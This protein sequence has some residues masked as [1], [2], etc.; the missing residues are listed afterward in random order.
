MIIALGPK[1]LAVYVRRCLPAEEVVHVPIAGQGRQPAQRSARPKPG[2]LERVS[3]RVPNEFVSRIQTLLRTVDPVSHTEP[4][5]LTR[6]LALLDDN[7]HAVVMCVGRRGRR[8]GWK[9][10]QRRPSRIVLSG[11]EPATCILQLI[12]AK[13]LPRTAMGAREAVLGPAFVLARE[14]AGEPSRR[15]RLALVSP[16]DFDDD[17]QLLAV[18]GELADAGHD[19]TVVTPHPRGGK[20]A[21]MHG[22]AL[23]LRLPVH[24]VATRWAEDAPNRVG[25][26]LLGY[27]SRTQADAAV[28]QAR[29]ESVRHSVGAP[30]PLST[31]AQRLRR[32]AVVLRAATHDWNRARLEK[33]LSTVGADPH[34]RGLQG[35]G[36]STLAH[37]TDLEASLSDALLTLQPDVLYAVGRAALAISVV[38][39]ARLRAQ[40]LDVRLVY[41]ET[42]DDGGGGLDEGLE[43]YL[44]STERRFRARARPGRGSPLQ[45]SAARAAQVR[46]VDGGEMTRL[47]KPS[48]RSAASD[49]AVLIGIQNSAGQAFQW[50]AALRRAGWPATSIQLMRESSSF[51]FQSDVVVTP[52]Q[53]SSFETRARAL[54]ELAPRHRHVLVESGRP[55]FELSSGLTQEVEL[56]R[57]SG[58]SVSM[59]FH[60]SDIRRPGW[61]ARRDATSPFRDP[62]NADLARHYTVRTGR[63][64]AALATFEGRV[65][66]S[67]PHLL[68]ELPYAEWL[69][70]VV[71]TS[72]FAPTSQEHGHQRQRPVVVHAPSAGI[73]KGSHLIDPI[74]TK[75]HREGVIVYRRIESTPNHMLPSVLASADIV[76]DKVIM[77]GIGVGAAEAMATGR[78]VV[79]HLTADLAGRYP[80]RPPVV[81][82]TPETLESVVR[83]LAHDAEWRAALA[84]QGRSFALDVHDGRR[85]A[86]V[87]AKAIGDKATRG[88]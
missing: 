81:D 50:A 41:S 60:G 19:T 33:R 78:P 32:S 84:V 13:G 22:D 63:T 11:M 30:T 40:G 44:R 4:S 67:N 62:S 56:L 59:V 65:F 88:K 14:F 87:L 16:R 2:V 79:S 8:L 31:G 61:H 55:I 76:V 25:F 66:V 34:V 1:R 42:P 48:E 20:D 57:K 75:M 43:S 5:P 7:P 82:A 29:V 28:R 51:G 71:D 64:H 24:A 85:S 18:A 74:L 52:S 70:V 58:L 77:N 68:D 45:P 53:W 12:E 54:A 80:T 9:V 49:S 36:P 69:P 73:F 23:V 27:R 39:E 15:P 21:Y 6:V 38:A 37:Q 26:G 86:S 35:R 72:V 47:V 10:A 83:D 46:V 3:S 17:I